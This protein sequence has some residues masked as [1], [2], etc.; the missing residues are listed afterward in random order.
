LDH[1]RFEITIFYNKL[2]IIHY[3]KKEAFYDAWDP[4]SINLENIQ[5]A[6]LKS[7]QPIETDEKEE[8]KEKRRKEK[9]GI[10]KRGKH[11][12]FSTENRIRIEI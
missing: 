5:E 4:C 2:D 11:G 6:E 3:I 9:K 1:D 10:R 12:Y 8:E 7:Y